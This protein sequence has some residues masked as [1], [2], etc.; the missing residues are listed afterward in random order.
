MISY[1][2]QIMQK[3]HLVKHTMLYYPHK[4]ILEFFKLVIRMQTLKLLK[5]L[6]QDTI[7]PQQEKHQYRMQMDQ[8]NKAGSDRIGFTPETS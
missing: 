4:R 7:H 8:R 6:Q 2:C 3:K 1:L 5:H